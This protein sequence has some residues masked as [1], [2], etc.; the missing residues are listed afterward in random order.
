MKYCNLICYCDIIRFGNGAPDI[1]SS[2][3]AITQGGN[4]TK[5]GLGA[6]LGAAVFDPVR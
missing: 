4:T 3:A 5:L 2:V 6:L 1:F